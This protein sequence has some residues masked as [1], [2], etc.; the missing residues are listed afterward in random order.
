MRQRLNPLSKVSISQQE[1]CS[2]SPSV[3]RPERNSAVISPAGANSLLPSLNESRRERRLYSKAPVPKFSPEPKKFRSRLHVSV[4]QFIEEIDRSNKQ[5]EAKYKE[6]LS[7]LPKIHKSKSQ[8]KL[9]SFRKK[10]HQLPR[11]KEMGLVFRKIQRDLN[12]VNTEVCLI[13]QL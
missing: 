3:R 2:I 6:I 13:G 9:R 11:R 1:S 4:E 10:K 5:I 8:D 7:S 12:R